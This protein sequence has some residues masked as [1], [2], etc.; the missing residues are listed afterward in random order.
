M[1]DLEHKKVR[2]LHLYVRPLEGE[3]MEKVLVFDNELPIYHT[4]GADIALR[5]NPYWQG[6]FSIRNIRKIMND[7]EKK[8]RGNGL[9]IGKTVRCWP[10]R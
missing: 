3:V 2:D 8:Y 9:H 5:K 4:T 6:M 7:S 10:G 1:T